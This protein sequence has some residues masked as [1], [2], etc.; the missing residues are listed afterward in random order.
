VSL[1]K[2]L[3]EEEDTAILCHRVP[4]KA[5]CFASGYMAEAEL[6]PTLAA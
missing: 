4:A 1:E 5:K 3:V 6:F 2:E